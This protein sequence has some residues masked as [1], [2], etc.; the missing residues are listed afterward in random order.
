MK[1]RTIASLRSAAAVLA[2]ACAAP[3]AFADAGQTLGALTGLGNARNVAMRLNAT[4]TVTAVDAAARL[5]AVNSA[6]GPITFRLDPKVENAHAIKVGD[7]VEVDYVAAF[8]LSRRR[9]N[10]L[11][12]R[13]PRDTASL[14]DSYDHPA[15]F[16]CDVVA[17]DKDNLVL[18]LRSPDGKVADYPVYER[19]E[20]AGVHVGDRMLASINQAVAVGVTPLTR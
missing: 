1:A 10:T 14:A 5:M 7:S 11:F 2:F 17:I 12:L 15:V 6:R 3:C 4:G 9:G 18:R 13:V 20:L 8:A 19:S 16:L